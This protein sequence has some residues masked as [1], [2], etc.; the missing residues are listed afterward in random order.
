MQIG[1]AG[2]GRMGAA[3]AARLMEVGH[4]VAVWNRT[5]GKAK[6]LTDAGAGFLEKLTRLLLECRHFLVGEKF[7]PCQFFWPLERRCVVVGPKPL[8][9]R[10]SVSG[11]G[12]D[13]GLLDSFAFHQG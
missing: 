8:K 6:P 11:S 7:P 10:M 12:H 9:V 3:M 2:L 5:P 13:P 1:I 4:T